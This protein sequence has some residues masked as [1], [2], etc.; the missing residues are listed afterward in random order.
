MQSDERFGANYESMV[1][2]LN[3]LLGSN[4]VSAAQSIFRLVNEDK[5]V[6]MIGLTHEEI[7]VY[8]EIEKAKNLA[9]N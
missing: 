2:I 4:R 1:P 9:I 6:K 8:Q 3:E 7:L 5:A